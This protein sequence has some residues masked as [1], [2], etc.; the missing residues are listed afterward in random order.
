MR[1][2]QSKPAIKSAAKFISDQVSNI[3]A[4]QQP[5]KSIANPIFGAGLAGPTAVPPALSPVTERELYKAFGD[6][7]FSHTHIAIQSTAI[8][9]VLLQKEKCKQQKHIFFAVQ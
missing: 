2:W 8:N 6:R 4:A 1:L 9:C 7:Y 5:S 3:F